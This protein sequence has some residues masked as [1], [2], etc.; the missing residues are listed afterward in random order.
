MELRMPAQ[1][2]FY[3]VAFCD[4]MIHWL[5]FG[6]QYSKKYWPLLV[7]KRCWKER[8]N[9]LLVYILLKMERK[10]SFVSI[11]P[12]GTRRVGGGTSGHD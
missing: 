12:F 11:L 10:M 7:L 1:G 2:L 4:S 6:R 9:L 8:V 3:Y 5:L